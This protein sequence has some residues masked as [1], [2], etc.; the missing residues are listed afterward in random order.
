M[1]RFMKYCLPDFYQTF[2]AQKTEAEPDSSRYEQHDGLEDDPSKVRIPFKGLVNL[3]VRVA[4][5]LSGRKQKDKTGA[6]IQTLNTWQ[7]GSKDDEKLI[8]VFDVM[9]KTPKRLVITDPV[10]KTDIL[11][12]PQYRD[13]IYD[14]LMRVHELQTSTT[15]DEDKPVYDLQEFDRRH[16]DAEHE[17][18]Q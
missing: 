1:F 8:E 6:H 17:N 16:F 10:T 18:F 11:H 2:K 12:E 9:L 14:H 13:T 4:N 15:E 7:H 3:I 5:R